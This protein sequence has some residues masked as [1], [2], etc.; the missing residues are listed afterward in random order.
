MAPPGPVYPQGP[1]TQ[2]PAKDLRHA[3]RFITSH[4]TKG[5]GTFLADDDGAHHRVMVNGNAVANIIYSTN[6]NPIDM[7]NDKDLVY[8]RDNEVRISNYI[9]I[10]LYPGIHVP[11]GSVAR[12]IDFAPGVESPLHRAMSLDYGVVIEGTFKLTLDSGEK[13]IMYPG[14]ISVNRGAM[15]KWRNCDEQRSGRMLFI[16][17]DV[18]PL[19]VGGKVLSEDLGDL[20]GEYAGLG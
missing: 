5:E 10:Y 3:R 1:I 9:H 18:K 14:D 6:A 12:L 16:L 8:A 11:N 17:L 2:F 13:R 15:H 20:A 4:N 19:I 7:N